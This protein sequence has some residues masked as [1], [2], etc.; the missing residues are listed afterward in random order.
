MS[1][2]ARETS[3]NFTNQEESQNK[4]NHI[5]AFI[6]LHGTQIVERQRPGYICSFGLAQT[7]AS[8][9]DFSA[10]FRMTHGQ[11]CPGGGTWNPSIYEGTLHVTHCPPE[12]H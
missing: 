6:A 12:R 1:C 11:E 2:V 5:H 4:H 3:A 10:Y 7:F 9:V 8:H